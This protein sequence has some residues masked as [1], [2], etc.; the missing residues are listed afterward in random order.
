MRRSGGRGEIALE[1]DCL[2]VCR[3]G[4]GGPV[5]RRTARGLAVC[6]VFRCSL[7]NS[8]YSLHR[9][10]SGFAI[11]TSHHSKT[12]KQNELTPAARVSLRRRPRRWPV[13]AVPAPST[14]CDRRTCPEPKFTLRRRTPIAVPSPTHVVIVAKRVLQF[15]QRAE[16]QGQRCRQCPTAGAHR[17]REGHFAADT[18]EGTRD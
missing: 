9:C 16:A 2:R 11:A 5:R 8:P 3:N 12:T 4:G 14:A 15:E 6:F 10:D 18:R 1:R 13:F 7:Q 17:A